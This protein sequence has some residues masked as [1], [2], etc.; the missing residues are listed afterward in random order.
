MTQM[1]RPAR[2]GR[3]RFSAGAFVLVSPLMLVA[4]GACA[5]SQA[6]QGGEQRSVAEYD[7]AR[8]AFQN[9]RLREAL[10]HVEKALEHDDENADAAHLGA[11]IMLMFCAVDAQSSDCRFEEAERMARRTLEI[12]P[13]MRDAKNTLGVILVHEKRYDE[14]ITLLK[15]LAEDIL[16]ASPEKSWGNLGW[17]YLLKGDA[18]LAIDALRR[19]IAAQPLFCVGHYRL[20]LA[21]EKRNELALAREAFSAALE[22]ES[23]E[24]Q[25]MQDAFEARARVS[26]REGLRDDARADYERCREIAAS[27]P[28]GQRCA[29]QLRAFP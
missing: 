19:A 22:T 3:Q 5:A 2:G 4:A 20:G 13:D 11:L 10:D 26:F 15:P 27:T 17:A 9:D 1:R 7:L 24:C 12:K 16:Y 23:P 6:G 29:A 21:Y 14:A 8:D 25:R 18:D 28:T